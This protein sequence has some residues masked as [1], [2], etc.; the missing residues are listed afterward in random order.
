MPNLILHDPNLES[1]EECKKSEPLKGGRSMERTCAH[2]R[3][4]AHTHKFAAVFIVIRSSWVIGHVT[5]H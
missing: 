1:C 4:H 5:A 2:I 3:T